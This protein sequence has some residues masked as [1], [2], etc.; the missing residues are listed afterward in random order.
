[1]AIGTGSQLGVLW[2]QKEVGFDQM[3]GKD[4]YNFLHMVSSGGGTNSNTAYLREKVDDLIEVDEVVDL[5]F[6][7]RS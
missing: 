5:S 6:R 2:D 3:N 1:M 7:R 4:V